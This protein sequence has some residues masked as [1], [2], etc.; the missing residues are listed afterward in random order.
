MGRAHITTA[1]FLS[2]LEYFYTAFSFP[3]H[4]SFLSPKIISKM[5][6]IKKNRT[7]SV[8]KSQLD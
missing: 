8:N 2:F 3:F 6:N 1:C 5:F 4:R 7:S